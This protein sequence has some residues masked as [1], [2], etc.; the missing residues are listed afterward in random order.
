[1][2]VSFTFHAFFTLDYALKTN[3]GNIISLSC[4]RYG[5][6]H[7]DTV[8]TI[9]IIP[10]C[11]HPYFCLYKIVF[12]TFINSFSAEVSHRLLL[13]YQLIQDFF[14]GKRVLYFSYMTAWGVLYASPVSSHS[15]TRFQFT[16]HILMFTFFN[17]LMAHVP[18]YFLTIVDWCLKLSIACNVEYCIMVWDRGHKA[19]LLMFRIDV[20]L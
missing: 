10:L 6:I 2:T 12:F 1:M 9:V 17:I 15:S 3:L 14:K 5:S 8:Y 16:V 11:Y 4:I 18:L 19:I 7:F 13:V 20:N